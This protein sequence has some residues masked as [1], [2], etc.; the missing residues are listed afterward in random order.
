M[1]TVSACAIALLTFI[2]FVHCERTNY[3][4]TKPFEGSIIIDLS[5]TTSEQASEEKLAQLSDHYQIPRKQVNG[6]MARCKAVLQFAHVVFFMSAD[7][8]KEL[9]RRNE[10]TAQKLLEEY[11][12]FI[13]LPADQRVDRFLK[14]R[15][16]I[17][18]FESHK[19]SPFSI[20]TDVIEFKV[21]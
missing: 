15:D 12:R 3:G 1:V 18:Y 7:R 19:Q 11:Q 17:A 20:K 2:V 10:L 8:E 6:F 14:W 4:Y 16:D 5:D 13:T 9:V 21:H